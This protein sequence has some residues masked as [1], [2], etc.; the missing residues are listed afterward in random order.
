MG[1][2]EEESGGALVRVLDGA[3]VCQSGVHVC[4]RFQQRGRRSVA[5]VLRC[6]VEGADPA[7]PE[8]RTACNRDEQGNNPREKIDSQQLEG[9]AKHRYVDFYI[10]NVAG[11]NMGTDFKRQHIWI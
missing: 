7:V 5:V 4:A 11:I 8:L 9:E 10:Y 2:S 1:D 6:Q 3:T